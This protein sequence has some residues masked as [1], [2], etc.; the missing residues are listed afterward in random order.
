MPPHNLDLNKGFIIIIRNHEITEFLPQFNLK[1]S[2]P[3]IFATFHGVNI[4]YF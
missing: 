3:Y 2:N 4:S 1:F